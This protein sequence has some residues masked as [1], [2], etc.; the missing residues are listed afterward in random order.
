MPLAPLFKNG[1]RLVKHAVDDLQ[2]RGGCSCPGRR[3]CRP[4]APSLVLTAQSGR[5][6][7]RLQLPHPWRPALARGL[8]RNSVMPLRSLLPRR[9]RVTPGSQEQHLLLRQRQPRC[10]CRRQGHLPRGRVVSTGQV[11]VRGPLRA[12]AGERLLT[13][14][15]QT[16]FWT[17]ARLSPT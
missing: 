1:A 15:C 5:L 13:P 6:G 3:R 12:G 11:G 10:S 4:S 16:H 8:L 2:T 14:A 17:P 9:L 7:P